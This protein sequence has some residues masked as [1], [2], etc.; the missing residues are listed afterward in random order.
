[1]IIYKLGKHLKSAFVG[2]FRNFWMSF[3]ATT[4]VAV[5]LLLVSLFSVLSVNV[6][7]FMTSIEENIT[8]RA[9]VDNSYD[10]NNIYNEKTKK[11]VLGDEIRS[12]DGVEKVEFV[13]KDE[14]FDRY[15]KLNEQNSSIYNRFKD[16][17]P[18]LH[19]YKVTLEKDNSDYDGVSKKIGELDGIKSVN[20][21]TGGIHKLIELFNQVSKVMLFFMAAL[22]LLAIFLISNTIKLTIYN[23]K[24]EIQIMR[25]V[26]A[27]NGYIRFP[28]I[29]E[30]IILGIFGAVI[31]AALTMFIYSKIL[32]VYSDGFV[33]SASLQLASASQ[34]GIIALSLF[35][36]GAVV[37][38]LGSLISVGRYLKV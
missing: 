16:K 21:G 12:I 32:E 28:F 4:A 36:I 3:S 30:G 13:H 31:P 35:G 2:I 17:N 7:S 26:G 18:M 37:G 22:I 27:S 29:L 33:I 1:M 20:Y 6:N 8:I 25:L 38:M 24:T 5:T 34:I 15:I 23:R 10:S 11:D 19:V 14:E 9:M